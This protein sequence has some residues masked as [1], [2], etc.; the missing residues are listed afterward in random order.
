MDVQT[1]KLE[2]QEKEPSLKNPK[3]TL[4]EAESLAMIENLERDDLG[5]HALF[6]ENK[7]FFVLYVQKR[8]TPTPHPRLA[9][10]A[11]PTPA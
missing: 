7:K 3:R 5:C 10:L 2:K 1:N 9:S 4:S 8:E 11:G 6:F